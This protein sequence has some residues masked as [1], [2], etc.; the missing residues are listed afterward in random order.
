MWACRRFTS[1]RSAARRRWVALWDPRTVCASQ[2]GTVLLGDA[3]AAT[4]QGAAQ[5]SRACLCCVPTVARGN[6]DLSTCCKLLGVYVDLT[7]ARFHPP[8]QPLLMSP[9]I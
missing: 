1:W 5:R 4:L 8:L 2:V 7:A 3:A 9:S 6:P